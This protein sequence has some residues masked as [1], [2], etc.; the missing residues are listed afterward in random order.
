MS[1]EKRALLAAIAAH[2]DEDTPRLA[3]ADWC[4]EHNEPDRAN[5]IRLQFEAEKHHENAP[6]R[7]D[8]EDQAMSVLEANH[9]QW[10]AD[11]PG[12][13]RC[14][15]VTTG[16]RRIGSLYGIRKGFP[17]WLRLKLEECLTNP[18]ELFATT[19]VRDLWIDEIPD[20]GQALATLALP[21][22]ISAATLG[23]SITPPHWPSVL[24]SPL[25]RGLQKLSLN[26]FGDQHLSGSPETGITLDEQH[27]LD[28]DGAIAIS[29]CPNLAALNSLT[30]GSGTIGPPG[31]EAL[32]NSPYLSGLVSLSLH[33]HPVGDE[34]LAHLSR[35][36]FASRLLELDLRNTEV[37]DEGLQAFFAASPSRL[38]RLCLGSYGSHRVTA[39]GLSTLIRCESFTDISDL[40]L[41]GIP[42]TPEH[43]R[44]LANNPSFASLRGIHIGLS[45]FDDRMAEELAA[46]PYVRNLRSID[47]QNNRVGTRGIAALARSAVLDTV[48]SL[49]FY[50]NSGIADAGIIALAGSE[51]VRELRRLS[52]VSTGLGLEGL[53]AIAASPHL[54]KLRSLD[55]QSARFGDE[56]ARALCDSPYLRR[57]KEL[58]V[59][60]CG[61]GAEMASALRKR[62]GSAV[63]LSPARE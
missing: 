39:D 57:I 37:G 1:D 34:G 18:A 31:V 27:V 32:V 12:W 38:R 21:G 53:R 35:S 23:F 41:E 28:D 22:R 48:T 45:N 56:G 30:L 29:R 25:L 46:S 50:N 2:P 58:T 8:L 19:P 61:I 63:A 43:I 15:Q 49:G 17:E 52:L 16:T 9:P 13:T 3:F 62:F 51:H 47:L 11:E 26:L 55:V 20:G 7:V 44:S 54:A 10:L 40:I 14:V 42:L 59:Y 6:A 60:N 33:G 36:P 5:F 24:S 4:D